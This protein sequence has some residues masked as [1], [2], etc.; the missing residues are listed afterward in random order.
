MSVSSATSRIVY[1]GNNSLVTAYAV[2]FYFEENAHLNAIAKT[3]AGVETVVTLTNH[4]GAGD[5][6]GGT[7]RTAVAVPATSTLTIY[8]EVPA[9]QTTSYAENDSFPAASHER[10]LDKLTLLAQQALRKS[11][12]GIRVTESSTQPQP[13]PSVPNSVAGLDE[14]GNSIFRTPQELVEFLPDTFTVAALP[15]QTGAAVGSVLATNGSTASWTGTPTLQNLTAEGSA[16]PFLQL[17]NTAA[18]VDKKFSRLAHDGAGNV[19]LERVNDGYTAVTAIL[20]NWD[21]SNNTTLSGN[22]TVGGSIQ[23]VQGTLKGA[24]DNSAWSIVAGSSD[25]G[26]STSGAWISLYGGTAAGYPGL[27]VFGCNGGNTGAITNTGNWG[28]GTVSPQARLHVVGGDVLI[29]NDR[30]IVMRDAAGSGPALVS[31]ID[32]NFVFYGTNSTGGVRPIFGCFMRSDTSALQVNVPLKIGAAGVPLIS[33]LKATV[34]HTIG[35]LAAGAFLELTS[36]V[37][38]AIAGAMV[39][40]SGGLPNNMIVNGY[41]STG[42]TVSVMYHNQ[43]GASFDAG[44][45]SIDLFVFNT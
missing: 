43:S 37:T 22:L 15:T 27:M 36:T 21:A 5:P 26:I 2:P 18:P 34:S 25:P 20:A 23:N 31:Q 7:V 11:G 33:A 14:N 38:G 4:T 19:N 17:K 24:G 1:T 8:R 16:Y 6:N 12:A 28:V 30:K 10:A 35:T 44:T 40:V 3:A 9:T 41:V 32:N 13:A 39:H 42:D 29:D 45:R